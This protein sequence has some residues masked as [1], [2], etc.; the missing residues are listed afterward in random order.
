MKNFTKSKTLQKRAQKV[1]PLGVNSNFRY[2]GEGVTPYVQKGKDGYL[3]GRGALDCKGMVAA[4]LAV[5]VALKRSGLPLTRDVI[6]LAEGDE[7]AALPGKRF[8]F[9]VGL[10]LGMEGG[11]RSAAALGE[12]GQAPERLGGRAEALDQAEKSDRPDP[13]R[14]DQAQPIAFFRRR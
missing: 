4:N 8:Q 3:W 2:W 5:M 12:I 7:D 10:G 14:A 1:T 6:F 13:L 11:R 9:R